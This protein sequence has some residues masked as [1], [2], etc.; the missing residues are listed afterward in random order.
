MM[1]YQ[2]SAPLWII[3]RDGPAP[4]MEKIECKIF[5]RSS[6]FHS[7]HRT[8]NSASRSHLQSFV[9]HRKVRDDNSFPTMAFAELPRGSS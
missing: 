4:V 7:N 9:Q 8:Q 3:L 6:A 2:H 5:G 1:L